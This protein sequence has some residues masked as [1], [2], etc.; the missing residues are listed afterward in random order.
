M[1][2]GIDG[3]DWNPVTGRRMADDAQI[4]VQDLGP[5]A[6]GTVKL[7]PLTVFVGPSNTGKTYLSILIYA[8]HNVLG[9]LRYCAEF[10]R[11]I[12]Y[13][14]TRRVLSDKDFLRVQ[15]I[16]D[17]PRK[18]FMYHDLPIALRAALES[19]LKASGDAA[20]PELKR[21]FDAMALSDLVRT[22]S[23]GNVFAVGIRTQ[24]SNC[25]QIKMNLADQCSIV[26]VEFEDFVM[27][28][29]ERSERSEIDRHK[30]RDIL[31]NGRRSPIHLADFYHWWRP[32]GERRPAIYYLPASRSAIMQ[33]HRVIATSLVMR[34]TRTGMEQ[35][36]ETPA[37]SGVMADY[38][39]QLIMYRSEKQVDPRLDQIAT[40]LEDQTLDGLV[41]VEPS[42]AGYP[43]FVYRPQRVGE[44]VGMTRVSS[45]VSELTPVVLFLRGVLAIGDTLI[46]E[47]PEA[48]LHPA[49]QTHVAVAL[50]RLVRAGVR[51]IIT[52]HSDWLLKEIGNLMREGV[53]AEET[54]APTTE[55]T[56]SRALHPRE[57]GIWLF[58]HGVTEQGSIIQEI[59]FDRSEGVEPPEYDDGA[60]ALY[61]RSANLQN[62]LDESRGDL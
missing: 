60:E 52:T 35:F 36:Q 31:N 55:P 58:R 62:K 14:D 39:Q 5:I 57:V 40:D 13:P 20:E 29:E 7:R 43:E 42:P 32:N 1:P 22:S 44:P 45:M 30:L 3:R 48:H 2:S 38:M 19:E 8:L 46:I 16:L 23:L 26:S 33:S 49:A 61:N 15:E 18:P 34:S 6:A 27:V 11:S 56:L 25:R 51:V 24:N 59:P 53:L 37:F 17:E 47:E 54:G 21:C 10:S 50:A 28:S 4:D 12:I 41:G 9:D